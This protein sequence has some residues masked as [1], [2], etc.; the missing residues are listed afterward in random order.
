MLSSE[1]VFP[2]KHTWVTAPCCQWLVVCYHS[3]LCINEML[4][5]QSQAIFHDL[6]DFIAN[7]ND[8]FNVPHRITQ[9]RDLFGVGEVFSD[10][11]TFR[12]LPVVGILLHV[13]MGIVMTLWHGWNV[14][15]EVYTLTVLGELV[16]TGQHVVGAGDPRVQVL[17][18]CP[19]DRIHVNVCFHFTG[20]HAP[21]IGLGVLRGNPI[22]VRTIHYGPLMIL[23]P[24]AALEEEEG[25]D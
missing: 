2:T 12:S 25:D 20:V 10:L 7:Q 3:C 22:K 15:I 23:R 8:S 1:H 18:L 24:P 14:C 11:G 17:V 16:A 19:M 13:M 6:E 21:E 4:Y 9:S 5:V